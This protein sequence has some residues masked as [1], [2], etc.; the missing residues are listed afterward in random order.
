MR[1]LATV[2]AVV[3]VCAGCNLPRDPASTLNR[4]TGGTLHVGILHDPPWVIDAPPDVSGVEPAIVMDLARELGA[5]IDWVRGPEANLIARLH[6]RELQLVI[7]GFTADL[8]WRQQVA[9]TRPYYQ[10]T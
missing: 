6:D 3:L 7:G 5:R 9:F 1:P 4:V 8:P 10:M 2:A